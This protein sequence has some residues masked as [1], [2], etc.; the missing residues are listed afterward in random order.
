M[1]LKAILSWFMSIAAI[2]IGLFTLYQLLT[3]WIPSDGWTTD[4]LVSFGF[5]F[6]VLAGG[7]TEVVKRIF[8]MLPKGEDMKR[9]RSCG[10]MMPLIAKFCRECGTH[11]SQGKI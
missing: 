4:N 2:I 1:A 10:A 9:C 11:F 5:A 6:F 3:A 8:V 7:G